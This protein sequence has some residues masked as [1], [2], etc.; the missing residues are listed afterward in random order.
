MIPCRPSTTRDV[1]ELEIRGHGEN[2]AEVVWVGEL[3]S[4]VSIQAR[5]PL[6]ENAESPPVARFRVRI[7]EWEQFEGDPPPRAD[8]PKYGAGTIWQGRLVYA[9]DL[10]L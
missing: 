5:T 3:S 6:A 4:Q 2:I 8:I 10:L 9:D 1:V 7:E